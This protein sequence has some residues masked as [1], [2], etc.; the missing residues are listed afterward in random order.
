M[1]RERLYYDKIFTQ[2]QKPDKRD[3]LIFEELLALKQG[4]GV[5]DFFSRIV[6]DHRVVYLPF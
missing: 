1:Y 4:I 3:N 2:I 6:Y 5:T